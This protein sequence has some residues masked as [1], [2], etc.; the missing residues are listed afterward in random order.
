MYKGLRINQGMKTKN[1]VAKLLIGGLIISSCQQKSKYQKIINTF[2]NWKSTQ[3]SLGNYQDKNSELGQGFPDEIIVF[4]TDLNQDENV[5]AIICF[6]PILLGGGN[7]LMNVQEKLMVVSKNENYE[8]DDST[9]SNL[10]KTLKTGWIHVSNASNG[11]I[12]GDYYDYKSND[13]Q[14]CPS[15]H[16]Q[17]EISLNKKKATLTFK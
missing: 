9:L 11:I 15:I 17:V 16:K 1:T 8:L 14:C 3:I 12:S 10:E 7:A 13:G 4:Y 2:E 5:D 6:N